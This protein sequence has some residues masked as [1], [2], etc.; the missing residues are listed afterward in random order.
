M[1]LSLPDSRQIEPLKGRALRGKDLLFLR[2]W[3]GLDIADCCYLL[4]MPAV[5]WHYYQKRP[6]RLLDDAGV[7][8]L[9]RALLTHPEAHFL[10]RFPAFAE[11]EPAFRRALQQSARAPAEPATALGL[12][13]GRD[14]ASVAR[15]R[16][17]TGQ[18]QMPP[19]VR[20]LLLVLRAVLAGHGVPGFES[21]ID[22]A[23][24][25]ADARGFDLD[26]P[27]MN[28]WIRRAPYRPRAAGAARRA[29]P[30]KPLAPPGAEKATTWLASSAGSPPA[31]G[32]ASEAQAG[33]VAPNGPPPRPMTGRDLAALQQRL[34][35]SWADLCYLLGNPLNPWRSAAPPADRL[36]HDPALA[37]LVWA[38]TRFP[39]IRY[40]PV[41]PGAAE[42]FARY[43][44]T[45]DALASALP[46]RPPAGGRSAFSLLLGREIKTAQR[47]LSA[48]RPEPPAPSVRRLLLAV[49][50]LLAARGAAGL[51]AWARR[52]DLEARARALDLR[53]ATAWPRRPDPVTAAPD[54]GRGLNPSPAFPGDLETRPARGRDAVALC[55]ALDLPTADGAYLLGVSAPKF[56]EYL[57]RPDRMIDD[58]TVAL[59]IWLLWAYPEIRFLTPFPTPAAVYPQFLDAAAQTAAARPLLARYPSGPAAFG[60]L[61]G[62]S[63]AR[64]QRWLA[65]TG[66][67]PP[68]PPVARLLFALRWLLA[69]HGAAGLDAWVNQARIEARARGLDPDAMTSWNAFSPSPDPPDPPPS[70]AA[71]T[72]AA[73]PSKRPRGRPRKPLPP[74]PDPIR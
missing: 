18:R 35:I 2:Q 68:Q 66:E 63:R 53:A 31:P 22:R 30:T 55:R 72:P 71:P 45:A 41:F 25:E 34:Q 42:V 57:D 17:G 58:P 37:L 4:G 49:G 69:A 61:L 38:L 67:Q 20:R 26:S 50:A 7:A 11:V 28:T 70:P 59:L 56:R 16:R 10:P 5:R 3:L 48:A 54:D 62:R 43:R 36:L 32:G 73:R 74:A 9:A 13:L 60:V 33:P 64:A 65:K 23:A 47:W 1:A 21:L 27:E 52:A 46:V 15:W 44:E 51:D 40:L 19:P 12:L 39:E 24:L 6:D 14:R 8:L 29:R